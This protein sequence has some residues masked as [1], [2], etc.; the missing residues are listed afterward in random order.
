MTAPSL[1]RVV[2]P[3]LCLL[4]MLLAGWPGRAQATDDPWQAFERPWF[5]R[6][7]TQEGLPHEAVSALTQDADGVLWI[8]T[9]GGLARFDGHRMTV[10]SQPSGDP[11]GH[12]PDGYVRALLALDDGRVLVGTNTGGVVVYQPRTRR[13]EPMGLGPTQSLTLKIFS[14]RHAQH[15]KVMVTTEEGVDLYDPATGK[16]APIPLRGF[17]RAHSPRIFNA[18]EEA[19]GTLWLAANPGLFVRRP[20]HAAFERVTGQGDFAR[21]LDEDLVWALHRD[22]RGRLWVGTGQSGVIV[23][24]GDGRQWSPQGLYGSTTLTGSRTVRDFL[25]FQDGRM[26]IATDG[27]GM[28]I[29]NAEGTDATILRSDRTDASSL[30]GDGVRQLMRDRSG[31]VWAATELGLSRHD[32]SDRVAVTIG[33]SESRL[34]ELVGNRVPAVMV[35]ARQRVWLGLSRGGVAVLDL[36]AGTSK[37][38]DLP[39]AQVSQYIR[40]MMLAPDGSVWLGAQGVYRVDPDSLRVSGRVLPAI[41][42]R[43]ISLS[44]QGE[45]VM[46][47]TY[48]GLYRVDVGTGQVRHFEHQSGEASTLVNDQVSAFSV[49]DGRWWMSTVGGLSSQ[50]LGGD[51]FRSYRHDPMRADSLPQDYITGLEP[52]PRHGRVWIGSFG[53]LSW[54]RAPLPHG[55]LQFHTLRKGLPDL[56]VNKVVADRDGN[57]WASTGTGVAR[58]DGDDLSVRSIGKRDGLQAGGFSH[59]AGALGPNGEVLFGSASGLIVIRPE[60]V[61]ARMQDQRALPLSLTGLTVNGAPRALARDD[62]GRQ[63]ITLAQHERDL[64]ADFALLDYRAARETAYAYRLLG[65]QNEWTQVEAGMPP[66]AVYTNLPAG[67]YTLQLRAITAGLNARTVQTDVPLQL[68]PRLHETGW[69][70]LLLVISVLGVMVLLLYVRERWSRHRAAELSRIIDSRTQE[71]RDANA[72]LD[73][74]ASVDALTGVLTRRRVLEI[75]ELEFADARS[76]G[77]P[78]S[79]VM[80]DLDAFKRIND[81]Y[82]HPAG[83]A[84][85]RASAHAARNTSRGQDVVGRYG[86]EELLICL[87]GAPEQGAC[88]FAQRLRKALER[89]EVPVDG[90]VLRITGSLGVATLEPGD[91]GLNA[92]LARADQAMYAAK[93]GGRNQVRLSSN[94][95]VDISPKDV[96]PG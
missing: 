16:T 50:V 34:P 13:F 73:E 2:G 7:T 22:R 76:A 17:P 1:A 70:R 87:P 59:D 79:L 71:L 62:E 69:A 91:D 56:H 85:L 20:G 9:F 10:F 46:V 52:D 78:F 42:A 31:N 3:G 89:L 67:Q 40:A 47:G 83:D 23:I 29:S 6:I 61:H 53:G 75:A 60:R 30:A 21:T 92:L 39:G 51:A 12:L 86:G 28:A 43:V 84:V 33:G 4:L 38:V 68:E 57:I 94:G 81:T 44:R 25:E 65:F 93:R 15:G 72:R 82:G 32:D 36:Q 48:D 66:T 49:L 55:E 80:L 11:D 5:D 64:R 96:D 90:Q 95:A 88:D 63:H 18:L 24:D 35:D 26:W 8:G 41:N 19:D 58:V 74:M 45:V 77:R 54:L 27:M 14:I 37:R